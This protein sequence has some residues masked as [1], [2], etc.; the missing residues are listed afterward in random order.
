[1]L[2]KRLNDLESAKAITQKDVDRVYDVYDA[3]HNLYKKDS[4]PD[5][6]KLS[7]VATTV[8]AVTHLGLAT[9]SSLTE[10]AWIGERAG[11]GNM[12][13][14]LPEAFRYSQEGAK[15]LKTA[16]YVARGDNQRTMA[17]LGFNLDPRVNE[18][19]DALFATDKSDLLN[20][21]FRGPLGGYLTQWTNFNRNWAAQA[22]LSNINSRANG[23]VNGDLSDIEQR[24]LDSELKENGISIENWQAMIDIFTDPDTGKVNVNV[25]D[26]EKMNTILATKQMMIKPAT[27]KKPA[28]FLSKEDAREITVRD[29]LV[30]WLHKVVDDVVVHPKATNK[31][32]WMSDPK[33]AIIAQLKTFPV[34]FG[35][36][37]VK[38]LLKK[39]NPKQCNPDF[40]AAVGAAGAIAMAYA[41]VYVGEMLKD[42]LKG[43]D[44]EEPGFR[45]TLDRAGLTGAPGAIFGSGRFQDDATTALG[46]TAFGFVN[47]TFEEFITPVWTGENM[48]EKAE[49]FPNMF[50]WLGESLDGSLGP[51]GTKFKPFGDLIDED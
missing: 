16:D 41:L 19:L 23:I 34:V 1:M 11:F 50:D 18:R 40:G 6:M 51:L 7:K 8:G 21:W 9:I 13:K 39:L 43:Q 17:I 4:N 31:P 30:P 49:A 29:L 42:A 25:L 10:L 35:N 26:D 27:A 48:G 46:G 38:R 36:T 32:M 14:T 44:F 12:L 15:K 3:V 47:R 37:V 33:W 24:R 45:E 2:Q 20:A 5:L 22:M 28:K